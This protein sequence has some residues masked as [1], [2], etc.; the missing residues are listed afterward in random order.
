MT[1]AM[2]T[3]LQVNDLHGYI[4]PHL[5]VFRTEG[6]FGYRTCGGLARIKSVFNQARSENSGGVVAL[7]NGDTFHGTYVA[8]RSQG[9]ALVPLMNGLGFDAMT[10]HWEFSYGPEQLGGTMRDLGEA[11]LCYAPQFGSAKDPVNIAGFIAENARSGDAPLAD[12][13]AASSPGRTLLDVREPA[14]TAKGSSPERRSSPSTSCAPDGSN[15]PPTAR[16][17]SCVAPGS[18]PTPRCVSSAR[19]GWTPATSLAGGARGGSTRPG[20]PWRARSLSPH[21]SWRGDP[22]AVVPARTRS[23][24]SH[25]IVHFVL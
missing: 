8:V 16:S 6:A 15:C 11:E 17:M 22:V 4:E 5:E 20:R 13:T 25:G 1:N 3:I 10:A 18:G 9:E 7:D 21:P 19:W 2:L 23:G 12:W 14:E 24:R